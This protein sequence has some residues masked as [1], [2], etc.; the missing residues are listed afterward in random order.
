MSANCPPQLQLS[1]DIQP[2]TTSFKRSFEQFGFDLDSPVISGPE[3]L[4]AATTELDTAAMDGHPEG[5]SPGVGIQQQN[6]RRGNKRPRSASS[7]SSESS[8]SAS[9]STSSG[10][11]GMRSEAS[12]S[13]SASST[14]SPP[15]VHHPSSIRAPNRTRIHLLS[16]SP[17]RLPTPEIQDIEM[18]AEY[19]TTARVIEDHQ[20]NSNPPLLPIPIPIATHAAHASSTSFVPPQVHYPQPQPASSSSSPPQQQPTSEDMFRLSLERFNAFD[21]EISALRRADNPPSLSLS[22]GLGLLPITNATGGIRAGTTRLISPTPIPVDRR[23][24]RTPPP[25]LPLLPIQ[26]EGDDHSAMILPEVLPTPATT[27]A[28]VSVIP[29]ST[30]A[31]SASPSI[32]S[33][34]RGSAS[35]AAS[36]HTTTN[37]LDF[38]VPTS[39]FANHFFLPQGFVERSGEEEE[40]R[41]GRLTPAEEEEQIFENNGKSLIPLFYCFFLFLFL[42]LACYTCNRAFNFHFHSS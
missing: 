20:N 41:T 14:S 38:H 1:I 12:T 3:D 8:S 24:S 35:T 13:S 7:F 5:R 11:S 37:T 19:S 18:P 33:T 31:S 16:P 40:R 32:L 34:N 23:H 4:V 21:T 27:T 15:N 9:A 25:T 29:I 6:T 36:N 10:R 22:L 26:V 39:P 28:P 42:P 17:P 30:P 2:S